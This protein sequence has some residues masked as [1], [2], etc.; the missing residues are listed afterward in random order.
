MAAPTVTFDSLSRQIAA[1]QL[2]PVYLLHGEEGYY[3]DKLVERFENLLTEEEKEFNLHVLYAPEVEP[4]AVADLCMQYPMMADRQVVIL[5]EAQAVASAKLNQLHRY[6]SAPASTTVLVICC[7]GAQAK[8]KELLAAVRAKGVNFES[9]KL[10]E[11]NAPAVIG[12]FIKAK[13]L[14]AE[15]KAMEMLRD[16]VGTDLSRLYNEIDKL[17]TALGAGATVTAEAVEQ[18]I[19]MSKDYNNFE[20]V[21]AIAVKDAKKVFTIAEYFK[22]NPKNNP[23]V[24]SAATLFAFFADLLAAFYSPDK[25]DSGLMSELK[26][27]SPW[28]LRRYR[29]A[30][31][32]YNP[33]QIIEII[34][35]IRR[36][37]A[38]SKGVG[39]RQA[40][41]QLFRDLLFHII[42]APGDIRF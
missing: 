18:N 17:T 8:G 37:D 26:L 42:T 1:G 32:L 31:Q 39:S 24:V 21:D 41:H 25:S 28:Q 7:R 20:L 15:P 38:M 3:I 19:G 23:L 10:S 29:A 14:K 34:A 12:D 4:G 40:D 5:K 9:K 6:V 35:A 2:A 16:Y 36:Y 33:F 27:R 11:S 22:A 30:M 13:G